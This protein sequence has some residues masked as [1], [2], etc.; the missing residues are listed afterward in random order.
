MTQ[1]L[2]AF[3]GNELEYRPAIKDFVDWCEHNHLYLN[4]SKVKE[5][6]IDFWRRRLHHTLV[7]TQDYDT[8]MVDSF[9]S[10]NVHVNNKLNW[11]HNTGALYK[12]GQSCVHLL[13]SLRSFG[14][15]TLLLRTL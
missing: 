1:L 8:D 12:M 3:E 11:S 13:R 6:V 10:L 5:M 7:N 15:C 14:V 4:T 2:L 9:K